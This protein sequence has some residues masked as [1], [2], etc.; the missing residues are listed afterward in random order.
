MIDFIKM[1]GRYYMNE[2]KP[3]SKLFNAVR[4]MG[5]IK[6]GMDF[7]FIQYEASNLIENDRKK[8]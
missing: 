8:N 5:D 7:P 2:K 6:I 3:M 4:L 1:I